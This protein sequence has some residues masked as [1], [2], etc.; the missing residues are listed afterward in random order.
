MRKFELTGSIE[1]GY[2]AIVHAIYLPEAEEKTRT[3][4]K[5]ESIEAFTRKA[6]VA[7]AE[8]FIREWSLLYRHWGGVNVDRLQIDALLI[9]L[10]SGG[11]VWRKTMKGRFRSSRKAA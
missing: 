2:P 11:R 8:R 1:I 4:S 5:S 3:F 7:R 6:A 10:K 9:P